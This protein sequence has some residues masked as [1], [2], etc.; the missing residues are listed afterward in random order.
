MA[1]RVGDVGRML[2]IVAGVGAIVVAYSGAYV[3][4]T[5]AERRDDRAPVR[6]RRHPGS[7]AV[8]HQHRGPGAA[9]QDVDG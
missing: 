4:H 1:G 3:R 7:G 6:R 5:G 8:Q 9:L 2:M